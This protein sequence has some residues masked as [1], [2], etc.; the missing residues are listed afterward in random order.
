MIPFAMAGDEGSLSNFEKKNTYEPGLF[1]D[2]PEG[3]WYTES[4]AAAYEYGLM[5]GNDTGFNPGGDIT[6]AETITMAARLNDIYYGGTGS[7]EQGEP[8]YL[9]YVEYAIEKGIIADDEFPDY[10]AKATRNQFANILAAAF[11]EEALEA[12]NNVTEIPDVENTEENKAIYT[13]YN[14]GILTGSDQYGTFNPE[15]NIVRR[16]VAAI[17]TRMVDP[18][19]RKDVNLLPKPIKVESV[20]VAPESIS[21]DVG[22]TYTLSATCYPETATD[23]TVTWTSSAPAVATVNA[24]GLV[25]AVG[26]GTAVITAK[27][28]SGKTAACTVTVKAKSDV[29]SYLV[30]AAKSYGTYYDDDGLYLY[31]FCQ[32][33]DSSGTSRLYYAVLYNPSDDKVYLVAERASYSSD[34]PFV[35]LDIPRNLSTP[36]KGAINL[37]STTKGFFS[38]NPSTYTQNSSVTLYH[39]TGPSSLRSNITEMASAALNALLLGSELVLLNPGGYSIT[40][41]GFTR[42][43]S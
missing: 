15:S 11:P 29:F 35:K 20:T 2:V 10:Q 12:K 24:D 32:D 7:F 28:S 40:N 43:L 34:V 23:K 41:L 21:L 26:G 27:A 14:A 19:L 42:F 4:V 5:I 17:V 9:V 13:L 30:N 36:Y 1:S 3:E 6:I 38:V 37:D 31:V 18:N 39:Y 25:T 22:A 16:E 8:W 33:I